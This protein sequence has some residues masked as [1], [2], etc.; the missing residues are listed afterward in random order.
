MPC[1]IA[2]TRVFKHTFSTLAS[3]ATIV[4]DPALSVFKVLVTYV[5]FVLGMTHN[6]NFSDIILFE[7]TWAE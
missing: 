5:D 3:F 4:F 7:T 2:S 1:C 6:E